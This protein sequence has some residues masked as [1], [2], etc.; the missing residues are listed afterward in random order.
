[1]SVHR[2]VACGALKTP[3]LT[4]LVVMPPPRCPWAGSFCWAISPPIATAESAIAVKNRRLVGL[5]CSL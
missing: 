3:T 4:V 1:M 5:G 2:V